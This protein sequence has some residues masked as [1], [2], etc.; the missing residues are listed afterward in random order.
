MYGN[1]SSVEKNINKVDLNAFKNYDTRQYSL[2]P[3]L[4]HSKHVKGPGPLAAS[5]EQVL[6]PPSPGG[7][8]NP[9]EYEERYNL[10]QTQLK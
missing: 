4:Q 1:M 7:S 10:K 3:G 8:K 6:G 2:V 9:M 5:G